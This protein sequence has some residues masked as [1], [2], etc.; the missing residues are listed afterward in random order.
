MCSRTQKK[1][2]SSCRQIFSSVGS[3]VVANNEMHKHT[4]VTLLAELLHHEHLFD[5]MACSFMEDLLQ[6]DQ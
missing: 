5:C 3:E 2:S 1:N 4:L 6:A